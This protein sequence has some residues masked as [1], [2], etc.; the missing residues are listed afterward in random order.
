MS[1]KVK[2]KSL[3]FVKSSHIASLTLWYVQRGFV[4]IPWSVLIWLVTFLGN[5]CFD[6]HMTT[7]AHNTTP[8]S[9]FHQL[10][11][12]SLSNDWQFCFSSQ[13]SSR[14]SGHR[15][16]ISS[17]WWMQCWWKSWPQ[18]K[19]ATRVPS[20][21]SS[22]QIE[23]TSVVNLRVKAVRLATRF[24]WAGRIAHWCIKNWRG[25]VKKRK[26][27]REN[28]AQAMWSKPI[29]VQRMMIKSPIKCG[30]SHVHC[31]KKRSQRAK[32]DCNG[33]EYRRS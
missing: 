8:N 29:G 16:R 6:N 19:I 5:G 18:G 22:R 15:L 1:R 32:L 31:W 27:M 24:L 17:H 21:I 7:T 9:W 13:S 14:Q 2:K 30:I 33:C 12:I 20:A 28:V 26:R 10:H 3:F 25:R 11:K 4:A 23:Q